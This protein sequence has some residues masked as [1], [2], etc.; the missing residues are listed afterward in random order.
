MV[1]EPLAGWRE[2][3]VLSLTSRWEPSFDKAWQIV[4]K[5]VRKEYPQITFP[6]EWKGDRSIEP[7]SNQD[8]WLETF[9]EH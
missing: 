4:L 9:E 2:V 7:M 1:T 6:A 3:M 8:F 5:N